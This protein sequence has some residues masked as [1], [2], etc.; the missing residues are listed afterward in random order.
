MGNRYI[1]SV[2]GPNHINKGYWTT[3]LVL[4]IYDTKQQAIDSARRHGDRIGGY[5]DL[6]IIMVAEVLPDG[7]THGRERIHATGPLVGQTCA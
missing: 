6:D 3:H 7:L 5:D 2:E 4:G 1:A